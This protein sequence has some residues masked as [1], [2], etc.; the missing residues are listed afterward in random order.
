MVPVPFLPFSQKETKPSENLMPCPMLE[1]PGDLEETQG[2]QEAL[3]SFCA[4]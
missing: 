2:P 4:I 3:G 1:V